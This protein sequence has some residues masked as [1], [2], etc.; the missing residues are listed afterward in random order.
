MNACRIMVLAIGVLSM[1]CKNSTGPQ[2]TN[3]ANPDHTVNRGGVLHK[4]GL[5]QATANCTSCHGT[6][7]TGGTSK[8]SCYQCHG[9]KWR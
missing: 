3:N 4:T 2:D 9:K 7:L 1:C 6:D 5:D 8:V